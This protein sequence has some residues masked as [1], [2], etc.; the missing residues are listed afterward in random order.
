MVNKHKSAKKTICASFLGL[1]LLGSSAA[2]LISM[3]NNSTIANTS[4]SKVNK[5]N[6]DEVLKNIKYDF[7]NNFNDSV[8]VNS[9]TNS[10][11]AK[12]QKVRVIIEIDDKA[13]V[14]EFQSQ[15]TFLTLPNFVDSKEG[16]TAYNEMANNQLSLA[17]D[18]LTKGLVESVD[19]N[20]TVLLNGIQATTTYGKL[21]QIRSLT[22]VK[23]AYVSTV[24]EIDEIKHASNTNLTTTSVTTNYTDIDPD[25]GIYNNDTEYDGSNTIVAVLDSGFDYTHE[26]F[27]MDV[28]NPAKTKDD[29]A[30]VLKDTMAY[31]IE[32]GNISVNDVYYSSKIPF[33]YDYAD[34]KVDVVPI[35]S[36][37]GT[38]VSGIIGGESDKIK[39]IAP[40]TQFAWMKVF[41]DDDGGGDSADI[42][43]AL[44]DAVLLGV[45]AIN[46]SLGAIGGY[47]REVIPANEANSLEERTNAIYDKIEQQGVS[48][49]IAAGNEYSSGYQSTLGTNS[50]K[51]PESGTIGSP[52]SYSASLTVA[53][54]NG[55]LDPYALVNG[56]ESKSIFFIDATDSKQTEYYFIDH[57]FKKVEEEGLQYNSDGTI[58]IPYSVIPGFGI[59]ANYTGANKDMTGKI[60]IVKRGGNVSFEDKLLAAYSHNA[61]G[62]LVYN[63]VSGVIRMTCGD[64]LFIPV[65]AIS[66]DSGNS[67]IENGKT[68]TLRFKKDYKAGPFMSD[69]SSWGPL[70]DLTLKPEITAHGGN[71]YS[72][73]LGNKYDKM[74]GTS[75][76]TPNTCGIVIV[77]REY[78]K[79][80]WPE[81]TPAEVTNMVNQLLMS[82]AIICKNEVGNP[83]SV[84]KQGAGLA[85]MMNAVKTNAYLY[86]KGQ[87]K[88]KLE[89]GDD[90][91]KT[92]KYVASFTLR[93][94]SD[95]EM[96]YDVSNLTMTETVSS[97]DKSVAETAHMFNPSMSVKVDSNLKLNG[98][99]VSVPKNSEGTVEVT[100]QLTDEEKKYID[101]NFEN[102]M[103]VEGY[104]T[105]N[106]LTA[107]GD[108]AVNLSIPFLAF[109]GDWLKAP[110]F[111]KTYYEVEKDRVDASISEKDKTVADMYATTPYGKYGLYYIIP[112]GGYLYEMD[113]SKYELIGASE[114]KAAISNDA[115]NAIYQLYSVY[116]GLLRG[117][118]EM[119]MTVTDVNTGKVIYE[120]TTY[121]NKK[122]TYYN[123]RTMPYNYS[124]D[125]PM[126][127]SDG[128]SFA[129]N[130]K[131]EIK[132]VA[133]LDYAN[134]EKATNNVFTSTFYVDYEA[135]TLEKVNYV[136]EWDKSDKKYKYYIDL[137][138]S[139]NRYVQ[140]VRPCAL[141][142]GKLAS[143]DDYPIP[144]YQNAANQTTTVR[145]EITDYF[146]SLKKSTYS[147]TIFFV[148]D[149]YA[150]NSNIYYVALNGADN[151]NLAFND[152]QI[153]V[154]KNS[155]IDL[156]DY[157]NV[158]NAMLNNF[159]WTSSNEKIV[160]VDNGKAYGVS[161]GIA[162]IT[163]KS[164]LYKTNVQVRV[165]VLDNNTNNNA[166]IEKLS[167]I[168]FKT[169]KVFDDDF[170]SMTLTTKDSINFVPD[171][172]SFEIY[173]SESFQLYY[174]LQPWYV[175]KNKI[176]V[177]YTSSND[178]FVSVT[179]DG[180][181]V[182]LKETKTP[183]NIKITA[184]E[185]DVETVFT[186]S[187]SVSVKDPFVR[188]G[189]VLTSY[190]GFGGDI[191][192]PDDLGI[193]YIGPYAFSHYNYGGL[194]K[195]GYAIQIPIGNDDITSIVLPKGLKY[196]QE[197]A[198]SNLSALKS[199]VL[200]E[201]TTDIYV[202]AFDNCT[203]LESI[204]LNNVVK[205]ENYAFRNCVKLSNINKD[206]QENGKDLSNV[207]TIGKN[208]FDS[209]A[210]SNVNL[211]S[212]RVS[213]SNSFANTKN[214]TN[215]TI[216]E[217]T[218]INKSMFENSGIINLEIAQSVIA[219]DSFKDN[220]QLQT[221]TFTNSNVTINESAFENTP[222]LAS[223][224]FTNTTKLVICSNAFTNSNIKTLELP[225]CEVYLDD[226]A[227]NNSN[228]ESLVLNANTKLYFNGTPFI[229]NNNFQ[230]I[231]INGANANYE[232][233]DNVLYNKNIDT[234]LLVPNNANVTISSTVKKIG[235][236]AFAG[237]NTIKNLTIPTTIEK[238]DDYAFAYSTI[239]KV[240]FNNTSATLG[241]YLFYYSSVNEITNI[242]NIKTIPA[243]TFTNTKLVDVSLGDDVTIKYGAFANIETLATVE[244]GN[245]A[246]IGEYAFYHSFKNGGTATL[247]SGTINEFA[248]ADSKL[249]IIDASKI[250]TIAKAAFMNTNIRNID[251]SSANEVAELAFAK[252]Y[253]LMEITLANNLTTIN[254]STFANCDN[255]MEI[256]NSNITKID[257]YAFYGDNHLAKIDLSK[258]TSIGRFA[259]AST[260]K[261][262]ATDKTALVSIDLSNV[263]EIKESAFYN[264]TG[265]TTVTN[266]NKSKLSE[267]ASG[268]FN[269]CTSLKNI[270]LN[271]ITKIGKEAF[272]LTSSLNTVNLDSAI[273]IEEDAFISS[274]INSLS[275]PN[276]LYIGDYAFYANSLKG[277]S[278]PNVKEI[279]KSAFGYSLCSTIELP[280]SLERIGETA[281]ISNSYLTNFTAN[282]STDYTSANWLI[283]NGVLYS[284]LPNGGLQLHTYP[285][286]NTRLSYEIK[287][288][289][290]RI[291]DYAFYSSAGTLKLTGVTLPSTLLS[292]GECA[293]YNASNISKFIFKSY[294]APILEGEYNANLINYLGNLSANQ[295]TDLLNNLYHIQTSS[296]SNMYYYLYP[297]YY[298]NFVDY[299]G[300][301]TNLTMYYPVN[302]IGY[303]SWI[304]RNYFTNVIKSAAVADSVTTRL[305]EALNKLENITA[306]TRDNMQQII[307]TYDIYK[308]ISDE[309]Q[310]AILDKKQLNHLL[311][312]Y[313]EVLEIQYPTLTSD[314]V[315][316][317]V[318]TYTFTNNDG[319]TYKL[320]I[321]ENG[322]GTFT[323]KDFNGEFTKVRHNGNSYQVNVNDVTFN[324]KVLENK[325]I[326]F[327][328][329]INDVTLVKE[330]NNNNKTDDN[331][332]KGC[333][334]GIE[335]IYSL[336]TLLALAGG[337]SLIYLKK[338]E[339]N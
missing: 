25:T 185:N 285:L 111:D 243:Y 174:D 103:Y 301:A 219:K 239:E 107:T 281:F 125:L 305:I 275:L 225:S 205:I 46:M 20:Y 217:L 27:N 262:D 172:K 201:E 39:G 197:G 237:N 178:E 163:G 61:L 79:T 329:Y 168:N 167:Y 246:T 109:Y 202:S 191:I 132:M 135:P 199:V 134:G 192:V 78:V 277:I 102:G 4:T 84:R 164:E 83:Y 182:A 258:V 33:M 260:L 131:L 29:I 216:Y 129:N 52:G 233:V 160:T 34:K 114:D 226:E 60:A 120:L 166:S 229:N 11:K 280:E 48:L 276:C 176:K 289:T 256:K 122:S 310:L 38:H 200:P 53:S 265:L 5:I 58:D 334:G 13:L 12:S 108:A 319:A 186:D 251:I 36:D 145:V 18:L 268:T 148:I 74:S 207:V 71:I 236:S 244:I 231:K 165:K 287:E 32:N 92:G 272:K 28:L 326:E 144:V 175:D 315:K 317:L 121:N 66:M 308:G 288:G 245:N 69:F 130:T 332:H 206:G 307:D 227:F 22:G 294:N 211:E 95:T 96:T 190:R 45:D 316:E 1:I 10:S 63:N 59:N 203:S 23:N 187:V 88:S 189:I 179:Q 54:I 115:D 16:I 162:T 279:G 331:N 266:L 26:V 324:F 209:T 155:I 85:T 282:N 213:F 321:N 322:T 7:S 156:N 91:E 127:N 70:P 290:I 298:A 304:Y 6:F 196:I 77:I 238:I 312:L 215:A 339:S 9:A 273:T 93:N 75:M 116:A 101:K 158:E 259:F 57:L 51:N 124:Y 17:N 204:N 143:L 94:I 123:G 286:A 263:E 169:L 81:L 104:I 105:L 3:V 278:I 8:L 228:I 157:V 24:Y 43:T 73:I 98:T 97:D 313:E 161:K 142:D 221:V 50:I 173:P 113:Q 284:V 82:T 271:N 153:E 65:A 314:E 240:N 154:Q 137:D 241:D 292:I 283:E 220:K 242:N 253:Y 184:Y 19:G 338:K 188:S 234:I 171:N 55:T 223:V 138:V 76:A 151:E 267:I 128:S 296:V 336:F 328:Y 248:F 249:K 306:A 89:L 86:V 214:L 181:V 68:G 62:I 140:S 44:E 2:P 35:E 247:N 146:S 21:D 299:V 183:I 218:P 159:T 106:N 67:I 325:D 327:T 170:E 261:E 15:K 303:D 49:I 330:G 232:V 41:S 90:K 320:V 14:D 337:L 230:T 318:G 72:S 264:N 177:E 274:N 295:L 224:K 235:H 323:Y 149:D 257:D 335:S 110:M 293:F 141:I 42:V 136:K 300:M 150:L 198:F 99:K 180:V 195:D 254:N 311:S 252:N 309:D 270:D 152:K 117:A 126:T 255:L 80:N 87:T 212:L 210:I 40:Q 208:A 30:N 112:L 119:T 100:L 222:L 291:G 147:D 333:K 37:H 250:T 133:K 31:K 193:Q 297:Y 139:D 56:D 47:S 269:N 302:G 64:E 194:D 118:K